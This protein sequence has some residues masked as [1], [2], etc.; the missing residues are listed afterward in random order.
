MGRQLPNR[1]VKR[2]PASPMK[3]SP[4]AAA[5]CSG[6]GGQNLVAGHMSSGYLIEELDDSNLHWPAMNSSL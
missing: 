2:V 5:G 1:P 6:H 4:R 3:L